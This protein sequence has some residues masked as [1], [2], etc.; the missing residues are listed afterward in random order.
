MKRANLMLLLA[1]VSSGSLVGCAGSSARDR[2]LTEK[3]ATPAAAPVARSADLPA[4]GAKDQ[5]PAPAPVASAPACSLTKVSFSYDNAT[6][7]DEA[8]TALRGVADCIRARKLPVV[9]VEGHCDE[10][11]T[12]EYNLALG[13]RRAQSVKRYLTGLG[14]PSAV[15]TISFGEEYPAV[16]GHDEAAWKQNRRAELRGPGDK[17]S[18]G[19]PVATR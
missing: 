19:T 16:D 10:R 17:L 9:K 11:G 6:L 2:G 8:R 15:Q 13:E 3:D 18:N 4:D 5:K 12:Q 1:A 7:S 14:V